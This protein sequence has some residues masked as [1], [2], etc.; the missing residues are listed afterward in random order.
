MINTS[1]W[2]LKRCFCFLKWTTYAYVTCQNRP[3][4]RRWTSGIVN[5]ASLSLPE[6]SIRFLTRPHHHALW[7]VQKPAI[8]ATCA[9]GIHWSSQIKPFTLGTCFPWLILTSGLHRLLSD[10]LVLQVLKRSTYTYTFCSFIVHAPYCENIQWLISTS[11]DPRCLRNDP[12]ARCVSID[13]SLWGSPYIWYRCSL[14]L[15]DEMQYLCTT[16]CEHVLSHVIASFLL[17]LANKLLIKN[18]IKKKFTTMHVDKI[19]SK[20]CSGELAP[21]SSLSNVISNISAHLVAVFLIMT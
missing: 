13:Q 1:H 7:L 15:N 12:R 11:F 3:S 18:S 19:W 20:R 6:R 2:Q 5:Y 14:P 10:T 9:Q 8:A 16:Q 21:P 4:E 17:F